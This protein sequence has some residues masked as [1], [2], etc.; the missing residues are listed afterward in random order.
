VLTLG[1]S[2]NTL[3]TTYAD[4]RGFAVKISSRENDRENL[5]SFCVVLF[6]TDTTFAG[7]VTVSCVAW[8]P[9]QKAR[10]WSRYV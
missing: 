9:V 5:L 3:R 1:I 10:F 8:D 7:C 2:T 4:L 6:F